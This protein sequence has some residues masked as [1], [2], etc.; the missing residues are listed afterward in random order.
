MKRLSRSVT[1]VF[2]LFE[3]FLV[4]GFCTGCGQSAYDEKLQTRIQDLHANPPPKAPTDIDYSDY[5]NFPIDEEPEA[6]EPQDDADADIDADADAD[7]DSADATDA[8]AAPAEDE[9]ADPFE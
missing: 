1:I 9:G 5:S 2:A 4:I 7:V 6:G 8:D 3:F